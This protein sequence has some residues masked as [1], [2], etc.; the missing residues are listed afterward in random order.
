MGKRHQ[1]W[2][3]LNPLEE[4]LRGYRDALEDDPEAV[5]RRLG[6]FRFINLTEGK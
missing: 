6:Q 2:S 1:E 4:R 3:E 5:E